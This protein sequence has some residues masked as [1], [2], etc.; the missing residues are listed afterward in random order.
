MEPLGTVS[1]SVTCALGILGSAWLLRASWSLPPYLFNR[2][3]RH[4]AAADLGLMLVDPTYELIIA[5]CWPGKSQ[6]P[7]PFVV[8]SRSLIHFFLFVVCIVE[9]QIAAGVF[10]S[11]LHWR[12][13]PRWLTRM[14][15]FTWLVSAAL[16]AL[17]VMTMRTDV[18]G[19]DIGGAAWLVATVLG[20][21]FLLSLFLY[22]ATIMA[23]LW[24]PSPSAVVRRASRRALA[25]PCS[26]LATVLLPWLVYSGVVTSQSNSWMWHLAM[27]SLHCN[28]WVNAMVYGWQNRH[29]CP[30]RGRP[31]D[32]RVGRSSL[33]RLGQQP[34]LA[35][36]VDSVL[37]SFHV[38]FGCES[39]VSAGTSLS[40]STLSHCEMPSPRARAAGG[41]A[42]GVFFE[43]RCE[44]QNDSEVFVVSARLG[45]DDCKVARP[46]TRLKLETARCCPPLWF[47]PSPLW[48]ETSSASSSSR[49][50]RSFV[51]EAPCSRSTTDTECCTPVGGDGGQDEEAPTSAHQEASYAQLEYHYVFM[52]QQQH[53]QQEEQQQQQQ[54]Q[55][56][57]QQQHPGGAD[58][59]L[60]SHSQQQQQQ[61]A[62]ELGSRQLLGSRRVRVPLEP[63]SLWL[64][65]DCPTASEPSV[66]RC[67]QSELLLRGFELGNCSSFQAASM[68]DEEAVQVV[69]TDSESEI[70]AAFLGPGDQS[71]AGTSNSQHTSAQ[72][73]VII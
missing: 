44:L 62:L 27:L 41:A 43:L 9:T 37:S 22:V 26:F 13:W 67:S 45:L 20:F 53:E 61:H 11:A 3:L 10:A 52:D 46:L 54:Q 72:P 39:W 1:H 69:G 19:K 64:V 58:N 50:K 56:T 5:L 55:Q 49:S 36:S 51:E 42:V 73:R 68:D 23:V 34:F 60:R 63:G 30:G 12:T 28:G 21:A 24:T 25:F 2:Q 32:L 59:L 57:Q 8:T 70:W 33:R 18:A 40:A 15:P 31:S 66:L 17:D 48:L 4:L 7:E 65:S 6:M 29:I 71:L 16:A 47:T 38:G 35:Q 14:L